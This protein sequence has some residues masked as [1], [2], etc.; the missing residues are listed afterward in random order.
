MRTVRPYERPPFLM[1]WLVNPILVRLSVGTTLEVRG[2][3]SGKLQKTPLVP[4]DLDG[5]RYLVSGG[6]NTQWARNLRAAG[7]AVLRTNGH[8]EEFRAVELEGAEHDRIVAAYH[9]KYDFAVGRYFQRLPSSADH[10][11][12]RVEPAR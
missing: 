11:A 8:P 4:L 7:R 6:G 5:E 10:A 12:F 2:R 3:R 9:Q 1:R